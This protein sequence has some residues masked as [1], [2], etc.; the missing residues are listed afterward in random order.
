VAGE[1]GRRYPSPGPKP[2]TNIKGALETERKGICSRSAKLC[3][4]GKKE[5]KNVAKPQAIS[6]RG[7]EGREKAVESIVPKVQRLGRRGKSASIIL[8]AGRKDGE[9]ERTPALVLLRGSRRERARKGRGYFRAK[10]C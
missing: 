9:E 10:R 3:A 5:K 4:K 1:K 6:L 7:K 2:S 8:A